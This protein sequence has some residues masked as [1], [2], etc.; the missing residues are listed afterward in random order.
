MAHKFRALSLE[1][2]RDCAN[3]LGLSNSWSDTEL[4]SAYRAKS[5]ETHPDHGGNAHDF[6]AVKEAYDYLCVWG[7]QVCTPTDV[8]TTE[9]HEN[10]SGDPRK[11]YGTCPKCRGTKINSRLS[12]V[13]VSG[14]IFSCGYCAGTGEVELFNPVLPKMQMG[15][16]NQVRR[17]KDKK[18][19]SS[20][21]FVDKQYI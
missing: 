9:I 21:R 12:T 13:N 7:N 11:N 2:A 5:F 20:G 16:K 3:R 6:H 14:W 1:F 15:N 10:Q 8:R 18:K 4:K 19:K 17:Q